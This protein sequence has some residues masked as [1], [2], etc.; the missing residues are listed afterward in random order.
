MKLEV[1]LKG[2]GRWCFCVCVGGGGL[3]IERSV[4][5][6]I[7]VWVEGEEGEDGEGIVVR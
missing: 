7:S 1:E 5:K 3:L 6:R 4:V 2:G